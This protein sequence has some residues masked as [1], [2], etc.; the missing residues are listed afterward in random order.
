MSFIFGGGSSGGGGGGASSGTQVSIAREAPEV[1]ARKL[2]LYDQALK[3]AQSPVPLPAY[4]VAGP[5]PN[6]QAGF[7]LAGQ[8][9]V[10]AGTLTSGIGALGGAQTLAGA[11]PNI[12]QFYNPYQSYVTDEI[13]RQ[14]Q[15]RQNELGAEAVQSGAFGGARQGVA[16][17]ELDRARLNQIGLSQAG[18]YTQ[19]LGAAQRQ[20]QLGVQTGLQ[21][22]QLYGQLGQAQQGMQQQD[23]SNLMQAGGVQQQLGQQALEAQRM[24]T[25]TRAY[26]P[27]Q[28]LEFMKGLMTNLPTGQSAMTAT[29]APGTNPFA[30]AVGTG[31]GAY[32]AYNMANRQPSNINIGQPYK[33]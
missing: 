5:P 29:T 18:G 22:G 2:S 20:Q 13:N 23:I 25:M 17:A 6:M 10:G 28:R 21:S 15:I 1:E 30:Q 26:E 11:A 12:S 33:Q 3:L 24:T 19:A 7:N 32:A 27:Y 9:G 4:Q 8:T 14:A 16:S 31:I